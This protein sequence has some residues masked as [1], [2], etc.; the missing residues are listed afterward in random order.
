M[1][2]SSRRETS[3]MQFGEDLNRGGAFR[4][5]LRVKGVQDAS[6]IL[7][8]TWAADGRASFEYGGEVTKRQAHFVAP[9]RY[10]LGLQA[11][12][13]RWLGSR[14]S[15]PSAPAQVACRCTAPPTQPRRTDAAAA[16]GRGRPGS[17]LA[18]ELRRCDSESRCSGPPGGELLHAPVGDADHRRD[19]THRHV[20][21]A[22]L[23]HRRCCRLGRGG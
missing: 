9:R 16:D 13:R 19:V 20:S 6:G 12:V 7:E 4:K 11:A 22:Q 21:G 10:P 14:P 5:G 17:L 23:G 15:D 18:S 8:M 3:S 2:L 1:P